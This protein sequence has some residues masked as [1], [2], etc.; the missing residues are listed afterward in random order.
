MTTGREKFGAFIRRKRGVPT[1]YWRGRTE[2]RPTCRRSSSGVRSNW[3]CYLVR[4]TK[5]LT[6]EDMVR[7]ARQ[8]QKAKEK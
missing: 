1:S 7:L 4:T 5:G 3:P 2:Y 8:A 6:A